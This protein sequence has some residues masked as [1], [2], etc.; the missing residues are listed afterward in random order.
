MRQKSGPVKRTGGAGCEGHPPRDAAAFFGGGEDPHRAGRVCAARTASPSCAAAKGSSRT[1][2]TAGRRSSWRLARSGWPATRRGRRPRTRSRICAA[3]LR[4]EGGRGR[5]HPREPS[6]QKKHD[7]GWGGR[8]MR[9]PAA[10]KLE[11]IRLVEQSHLPV[12]AHAGEARH[13]PG[14][15]L[16]LVRPVPERRAGGP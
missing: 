13:S 16:P 14:D 10:E 9:Y 15:L 1:S 7:R 11:I 12:R 3:R 6:A 8:R 2:I 4:A 5:A